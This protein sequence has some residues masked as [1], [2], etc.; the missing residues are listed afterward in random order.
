MI[1]PAS[2]PDCTSFLV[3]F[4]T[5]TDADASLCTFSRTGH[6]ALSTSNELL[7]EKK[8]F[9]SRPV[10][11]TLDVFS[12][13]LVSRSCSYRNASS[14][15]ICLGHVMEFFVLPIE[16]FLLPVV[17][18]F[19]LGVSRLVRRVGLP[20]A[21][22]VPSGVSTCS[23]VAT[24]TKLLQH[25]KASRIRFALFPLSSSVFS[26]LFVWSRDVPTMPK[27]FARLKRKAV[28][29]ELTHQQKN[30]R[31]HSNTRLCR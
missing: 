4:F 27:C 22:D 8:R 1:R 5:R 19:L 2:E 14:L 3:F 13:L 7:L 29:K 28:S 18:R 23:F 9:R 21:L 11:Q 10:K 15:S 16:T 6:L 17:L 30:A 24:T 25:L 20:W 26:V 31:A 12:V